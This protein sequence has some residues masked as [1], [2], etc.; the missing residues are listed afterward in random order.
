M[1]GGFRGSLRDQLTHGLKAGSDPR[2]DGEGAG[3]CAG[4]AGVSG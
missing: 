4:F 3:W 2:K 1:F